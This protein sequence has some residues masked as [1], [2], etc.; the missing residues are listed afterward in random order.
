MDMFAAAAGVVSGE[1]PR[2]VFPGIIWDESCEDEFGKAVLEWRERFPKVA[3]DPKALASTIQTE[4]W[5]I[6]LRLLRETI[7]REANEAAILSEPHAKHA[8]HT[9]WLHRYGAELTHVI[10][11]AT[12]DPAL[13]S[14]NLGKRL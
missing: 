7:V 10:T 2:D 12:R 11:R 1:V 5:A 4:I 13:R 9:R 14:P 6:E 3:D 8:I